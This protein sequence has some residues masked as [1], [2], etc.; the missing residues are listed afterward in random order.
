MWEGIFYDGPFKHN[1]TA[2]TPKEFVGILKTDVLTFD[3]FKKLKL[4]CYK[5]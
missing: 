4:S 5:N 2:P 1:N 3:Q